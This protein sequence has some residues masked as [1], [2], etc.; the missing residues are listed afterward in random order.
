MEDQPCLNIDQRKYS[1]LVALGDQTCIQQ[2]ITPCNSDINCEP[3]MYRLDTSAM[4]AATV[5]GGWT[6]PSGRI[7]SYAGGGSVGA[8]NIVIADPVNAVAGKP[9][10][11]DFEVTLVTGVASVTVRT[12]LQS[13]VLTYDAAGSYSVIL[14]ASAAA[15]TVEFV[16]NPAATAAGDTFSL[17][18]VEIAGVSECWRDNIVDPEG[19]FSS[20]GWRYYLD[21]TIGSFCSDIVGGGDLK[22]L[23]AYTTDNRYHRVTFT[24]SGMTAGSVQVL[25][26]GVLIGKADANAQWTFYGVPTDTT[27]EL[28]FRKREDFDG[29]IS[30]VTVDDFGIMNPASPSTSA[31]KMRLISDAGVVL[32]DPIAFTIYDDFVTWCFVP[33]SLSLSGV[34]VNLVCGNLYKY[35]LSY[36]CGGG[37]VDAES[38]TTFRFSP[39]WE[40]TYMVEGWC[41]GHNLGFYFGSI[42]APSFT[43]RHRLRV[44]QFAPRYP[45]EG[46]E[47]LYSDGVFGRSYAQRGKI[48]TAWFDYVDEVVHDCIATQMVCDVIEVNNIQY[49]AP[50]KDYEPEWSE[51]KYNLAQ[52]RVDLVR[53][54]EN[55]IFKRNC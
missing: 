37:A 7:Y 24:L 53:V 35:Q 11:I 25:I 2:K 28:R 36:N 43:L 16:M 49:F 4:G 19:S 22:N 34:G 8:C 47:Y 15:T 1:Q 42:T 17:T 46:E 52:S 38:V 41:D 45:V 26:G 29:C 39:T 21:G 54:A 51:N 13:S 55:T 18:L 20:A 50:V 33:T 31:V 6:N 3:D 32:S 48:R 12:D 5:S 30:S 27:K 10:K 44:L 23:N 14:I 40:C 9:Y